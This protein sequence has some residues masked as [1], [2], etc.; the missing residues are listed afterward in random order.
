MKRAFSTKGNFSRESRD[1]FWSMRG[2]RISTTGRDRSR[3]AVS[4]K[5]GW[6]SGKEMRS[7][8]GKRRG[9]LGFST[10]YCHLTKEGICNGWFSLQRQSIVGATTLKR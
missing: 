5:Q 9:S 10:R 3:S 7:L 6:V 1:G 2:A 4:I 8:L